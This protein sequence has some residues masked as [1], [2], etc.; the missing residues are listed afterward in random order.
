MPDEQEEVDREPLERLREHIDKAREDAEDHGTIPD[1]DE[2]RF[3]QNADE[4]PDRAQ[5][6]ADDE[7][8]IQPPG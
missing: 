8:G 6:V 5:P 7:V 2:P 1:P 4:R 3:Y